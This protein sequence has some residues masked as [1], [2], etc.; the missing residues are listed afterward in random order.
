M[1]DPTRRYPTRVRAAPT[2]YPGALSAQSDAKT[3]PA[4]AAVPSTPPKNLAD[5][6][7]RPD[8]PLW[9]EAIREEVQAH[10]TNW[11]YRLTRLPR[12]AKLTKADFVFTLKRDA[13]GNIV[14]YKARWVAKG[15]S[16]MKGVDYHET[17]APVPSMATVRMLFAVAAARDL[18]IH[19]LDVRTAYLNADIDTELYLEQPKGFE[20]G[21]PEMVCRVLRA[22]Y[23]TKQAGRLW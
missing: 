16:M 8:W 12:G 22:I 3:E 10:L 14:R 6:K 15:Y 1:A 21:G 17:W 11:T 4:A 19:Q 5:A 18:E 23:G 9:R 20:Q 2:R 7:C 13:A